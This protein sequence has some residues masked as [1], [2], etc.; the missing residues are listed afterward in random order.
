[1]NNVDKNVVLI[2]DQDLL[3]NEML[4]FHPNTNTRTIV[5]KTGDFLEIMNSL[6]HKILVENL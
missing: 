3:K 4:G 1:M 6:G 2:I 5:L